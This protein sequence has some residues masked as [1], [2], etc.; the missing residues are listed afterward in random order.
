MIIMKKTIKLIIFMIIGFLIIS[1]HYSC[2][3]TYI[4][5][6]DEQ[7]YNLTVKEKEYKMSA[8]KKKQTKKKTNKKKTTQ[9]TQKTTTTSV[10]NSAEELN[11]SIT[12]EE[13]TKSMNPDNA[14]KTSEKWAATPVKGI[15]FLVNKILGIIQVI[16]GFLTV[17][18]FAIF[19]FG[20]VAS[21]NSALARDL[22]IN[23]TPDARANIMNFGRMLLIGSVLLFASSTIVQFVFKAI[24]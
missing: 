18:S 7:N 4:A 13:F 10:S 16:G 19:G 22:G 11:T 3:A 20:L 14:G 8:T 12:S 2:E 21:G 6:I 23:A 9:S 1:T 5:N 15:K 24:N 17:I